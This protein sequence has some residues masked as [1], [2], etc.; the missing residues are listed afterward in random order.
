MCPAIIKRMKKYMQQ[1]ILKHINSIL[2]PQRVPLVRRDRR[3]FYMNR[4]ASVF[5]Q[6]MQ[7]AGLT[8]VEAM[9]RVIDSD[10]YSAI[11][12]D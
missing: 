8:P 6:V 9:E 12:V 5:R 10:R 3:F 11:K 1:I 4:E 7:N 2:T